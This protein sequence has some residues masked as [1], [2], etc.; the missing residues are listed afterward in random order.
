M[1]YQNQLPKV[2]NVKKNATLSQFKHHGSF[3]KFGTKSYMLVYEKTIAASAVTSKDFEVVATQVKADDMFSPPTSFQISI[4][5]AFKWI[6]EIPIPFTQT[7]VKKIQELWASLKRGV[8]VSHI[9]LEFIEE[10]RIPLNMDEV[11]INRDIRENLRLLLSPHGFIVHGQEKIL[12]INT[13]QFGMSQM[14]TSIYNKK[15]YRR[16]DCSIAGLQICVD[17]DEFKVE[18]SGIVNELGMDIKGNKKK[19]QLFAG[20]SVLASHLTQQALSQDAIVTKCNI[21]GILANKATNSAKLFKLIINF[22]RNHSSLYEVDSELPIVDAFVTSLSTLHD[23]TV[24]G[25]EEVDSRIM[26]QTSK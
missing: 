25:L 20:M 24:E 15:F 9:S 7:E 14:D 17:N 18:V 16:S 5:A 12:D 4:A 19:Y 8:T 3:H 1:N 6:T 10:K 13:C 21:F 26:E 11:T 22:E 2:F 23:Y